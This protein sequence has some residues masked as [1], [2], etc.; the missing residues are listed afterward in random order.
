[1]TSTLSA[2]YSWVVPP[3]HYIMHSRECHF[4]I[5]S[6]SDDIF[7]SHTSISLL[8]D[9]DNHSV[10]ATGFYNNKGFHFRMKR[11]MFSRIVMCV[12]DFQAEQTSNIPRKVEQ[13]MQFGEIIDPRVIKMSIIVH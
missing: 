13:L 11:H 4:N 3:Y 10:G 2:Q 7:S 6:E 9:V 8:I 5:H 1:M 12:M